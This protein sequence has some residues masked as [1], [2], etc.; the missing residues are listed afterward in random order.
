MTDENKEKITEDQHYVPQFYLKQ[1]LDPTGGFYPVKIEE[2]IPP[3]LKI[4][5]KKSDQ[6]R[7]CYENF[8]YAQ[9]TGVADE[10][11][12]VIEKKFAEIEAIFSNELPILEKKIV[13]CEQI[14]ESEKFHLAECMIFLHFRGKKYLDQSKKMTDEVTKQMMKHWVQYIDKSPKSKARME[15]SGLT[16]EQMVDYVHKGEFTVDY[17]N[18][19]HL[20]IMKDMGG[21]CNILSAKFWRVYISHEGHFITTDAPYLDMPVTN[22]FFGNDFLSREQS[23]IL[24]PRVMI[25]ALYPNNNNGKKFVRKDITNNRAFIQQLNLHNLMNAI[26]FGFHKDRDLLVELEKLIQFVHQMKIREKDQRS[27]K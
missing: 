15:E 12:Q 8:F 5:D 1:W 14:S 9:H 6:S 19:H 4:F 3:K 21:F 24:S 7:F 20:Q 26:R 23:F 17:G 22:T 16:K 10:V 11:S 13:N 25:V 2:K 18:M 27:I